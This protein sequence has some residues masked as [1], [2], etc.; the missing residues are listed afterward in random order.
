M[1]EPVYDELYRQ[2]QAMLPERCKGC[3]HT[4][5]GLRRLAAELVAGQ[6][7]HDEAVQE[8][9]EAAIDIERYCVLGYVASTM[10]LDKYVCSFEI[11]PE[12]LEPNREINKYFDVR[13][14]N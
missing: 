9:H 12:S 5:K 8:M 2:M 6:I 13:F 10:Y 14:E 3:G 7:T 1:T 4:S 11:K